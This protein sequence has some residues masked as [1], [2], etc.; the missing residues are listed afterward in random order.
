MK[1]VVAS[2]IY[3]SHWI[4]GSQV[5]NILNITVNTASGENV[6]LYCANGVNEA[7]A[8]E[9]ATDPYTGSL[10]RIQCYNYESFN[11][12]YASVL[13]WLKNN[14]YY[15]GK[16][17]EFGRTFYNIQWIQFGGWTISK[18]GYFPGEEGSGI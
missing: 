5:Y 17:E 1:K 6:N 14:G 10:S 16:R 15:T 12:M 13:R 11:S 3:K 9:E 4:E 2:V 7:G 18:Y 8:M